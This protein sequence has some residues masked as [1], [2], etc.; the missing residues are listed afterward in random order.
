VPAG[1]PLTAVKA[2]VQVTPGAPAKEELGDT[3]RFE[4]VGGLAAAGTAQ[5]APAP[6]N[7]YLAPGRETPEALIGAIS[8]GLYV[9]EL[10]GMGVNGVTGDYSRG[11][12][13]FMIR[14]GELAEPVAEIT[15]AGNLREMFATLTPANDLAFRFGTDAPTVR[16][17]AMTMAGR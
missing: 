16:I 2:K 13:G 15:I 7:L 1:S 11:A 5:P 14:N 6:S 3:V 8:E 4:S 9:T 10:I 17:A 12:A